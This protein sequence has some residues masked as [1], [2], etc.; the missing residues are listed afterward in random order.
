VSEHKSDHRV[1]RLLEVVKAKL[2]AVDARIEIG[3]NPPTSPETAWH[4]FSHARVV[5]VFDAPIPDPELMQKRL[6][7]L[8]G[9]FQDIVQEAVD[10]LPTVRAEDPREQLD[11][12][13]TALAG[14]A[15]ATRA[16]VLDLNSEVI[17]G[18]SRVTPN[19][20]QPQEVLEQWANDVRANYT[21]DLRGSRGHVIRVPVCSD[22]ECLAKLFGGVYVISLFFDGPLSEP[23]AVGALLHA[24]SRI[25]R[26]VVALPP[27]EPP[28]G[29]KV[30][31]LGPRI[32]PLW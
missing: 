5:A 18:I 17:W 2:G 23:V 6:A 4:A 10:R 28:P 30:L 9:G 32:R 7:S 25:E 22:R 31:R 11:E 15:G 3:G 19:H 13:L 20:T 29:G 8:C 12:E 24:A 26:L 14:R 1:E 21:A 27:I 16:I